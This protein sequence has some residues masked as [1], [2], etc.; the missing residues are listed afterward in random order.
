MT[1]ITGFTN[2]T[3]PTL[4]ESTNETYKQKKLNKFNEV[5]SVTH[6]I[7]TKQ[8]INGISGGEYLNKSVNPTELPTDSVQ[9]EYAAVESVKNLTEKLKLIIKYLIQRKQN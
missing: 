9:T 4:E 5:N 3:L 1:G 6:M 8:T 2:N 7:T